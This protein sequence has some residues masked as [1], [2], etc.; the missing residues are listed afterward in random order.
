MLAALARR[1]AGLAAAGS[2]GW[3]TCPS[4]SS[5][6]LE[7][8]LARLMADHVRAAAPS[9]DRAQDLVRTLADFDARLPADLVVLSR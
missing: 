4:R 6:R 2:S 7:R 8:A 3:R 1:D 9:A 5:E